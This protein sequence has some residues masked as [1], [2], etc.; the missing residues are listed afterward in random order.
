MRV[1]LQQQIGL[2]EVWKLVGR[3][4]ELG[5]FSPL[6]APA[7]TWNEG[8]VWTY[9]GRVRPGTWL[10]KV[11]SVCGACG[12]AHDAERSPSTPH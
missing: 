3:V 12:G 4:P 5:N 7:L 8:H 6:V 10:F 9:E 1:R 2:G 11:T